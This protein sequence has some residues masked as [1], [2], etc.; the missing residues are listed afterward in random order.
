MR[1]ELKNSWHQIPDGEWT[2]YELVILKGAERNYKWIVDIDGYPPEHFV[3]GPS[4]ESNGVTTYVSKA[5]RV[6]CKDGKCRRIP[7]TEITR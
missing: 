3:G 7:G 2:A 5:W 6:R 4:Y 1:Y